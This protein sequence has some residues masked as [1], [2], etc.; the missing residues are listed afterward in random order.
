[1]TTKINRSSILIAA[2]IERIEADLQLARDDVALL[3]RLKSATDRVVRLVAEHEKATAA[4]TKTLAAEAK[5]NDE[6]RFA[7][8]SDV[9]VTAAKTENENV[10]RSN[11]TIRYSTPTWD[12]RSTRVREHS[13]EGFGAL[14]PEVLDYIIDK[15]PDLIPAK[16]IALAPDSPRD[17]F[18]RYFVSLRRGYV[19]A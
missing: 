6:R 7:G 8:I 11:F 2:E 10:V 18:R 9:S 17:A 14:P 16:I 12:G 13:R 15:C 4:R 1:M 19:A 3:E 5:A